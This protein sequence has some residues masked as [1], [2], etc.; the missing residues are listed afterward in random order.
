MYRIIYHWGNKVKQ[1]LQS[2]RRGYGD[3]DVYQ[4]KDVETERIYQM[5]VSYLKA[6]L[7]LTKPFH[8]RSYE[9]DIF[10]T[11]QETKDILYNLIRMFGR[12]NKQRVGKN[13]YGNLWNARVTPNNSIRIFEM[14]EDVDNIVRDNREKAYKELSVYINSFA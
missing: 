5:L 8:L 2:A 13:K 14:M 7:P 9:N 1:R 10:Y 3:L 4:F 6:E 11:D 12:C